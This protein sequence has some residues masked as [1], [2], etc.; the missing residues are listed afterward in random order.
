MKKLILLFAALCCMTVVQAEVVHHEQSEPTASERGFTQECWEDTGTGKVYADSLGTQEL[1]A[2]EVVTYLRLRGNPVRVTD[3]FSSK[4]EETYNGSLFNWA[5]ET[6]Y[7]KYDDTGVR[8]A[9]FEVLGTDVANARLKWFKDLGSSQFGWFTITV[10]VNDNTV[11][12][13]TQVNGQNLEG[14][15]SIPLPGLKTGDKVMFEVDRPEAAQ[16]VGSPKIAACLE[17]TRSEETLVD[18][19]I[20]ADDKHKFWDADDPQ[21]T[22][23]IT[24]G[25]LDEGDTLSGITATRAQGE[26]PGTYAITLSQPEGANPRYRITFDNGTMTIKPA[27]HFRQ[28]EPYRFRTGHTQEC[29]ED[30]ET[31]KLYADGQGEHELNPA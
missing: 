5:A 4:I 3:G 20:K 12:T 14:L 13:L 29:W 22:W 9:E 25:E 27:N 31:G 19:R 8:Y 15:F 21:L 30:T 26:E 6:V 18:L 28:S 1:N 10:Y 24:Q 11:F 16:W 7:A 17:Y 2:A 23:E